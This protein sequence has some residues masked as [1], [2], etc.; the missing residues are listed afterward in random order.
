MGGDGAFETGLWDK[1]WKELYHQYRRESLM[2]DGDE[3]LVAGG[4]M[5]HEDSSRTSASVLYV[6]VSVCTELASQEHMEGTTDLPG[7]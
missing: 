3:D 4:A 2:S 6:G 1:H 5:G 7:V